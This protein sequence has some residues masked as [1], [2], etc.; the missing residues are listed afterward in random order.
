MFV[1]RES[2]A[3]RLIMMFKENIDDSGHDFMI[4][5][6]VFD[7]SMLMMMTMGVSCSPALIRSQIRW[8]TPKK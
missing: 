5:I 1:L 8:K 4:K 6:F 7:S 3:G 2:K